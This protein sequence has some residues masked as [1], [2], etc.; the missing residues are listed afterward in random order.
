[1]HI[2]C[3]RGVSA[4][5]LL[6]YMEHREIFGDSRVGDVVEPWPFHPILGLGAV[7]PVLELA[8]VY[9][10]GDG[11]AG[12]PALPAGRIDDVLERTAHE[13]HHAMALPWPPKEGA[14]SP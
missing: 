1:M 4:P 10:V 13:D 3:R 7:P 14:Y 5:I 12:L 9:G 11:D 6:V 8:V 2:T